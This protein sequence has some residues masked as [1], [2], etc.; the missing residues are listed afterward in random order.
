M[1][2]DEKILDSLNKVQREIDIIKQDIKS[3]SLGPTDNSHTFKTVVKS[4]QNNRAGKKD[5]G[6]SKLEGDIDTI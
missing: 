3:E 2:K 5:A 6:S 4:V 1:R